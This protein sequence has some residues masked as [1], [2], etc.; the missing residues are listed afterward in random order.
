MTLHFAVSLATSLIMQA[1]T[2][3]AQDPPPIRNFLRIST[4]VCTGGQPRP[5]HFATLKAEGTRA[6]LN[7]RTPGE[8][9][10]D[11]EVA[12][13]K[14]AGLKYF[15]IPVVYMAPTEAQVDEFLKITDD[16]ANRP[17]F[18]HCT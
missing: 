11:D 9:R 7:L 1:A 10:I 4:D 14:A 3:P 8:Y 16:P 6:V 13:V 5:E 15:N 18:I 12:A 17:I 2:A